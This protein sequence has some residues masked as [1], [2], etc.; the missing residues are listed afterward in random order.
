MGSSGF[1]SG[2]PPQL[3]RKEERARSFQ[4]LI[5]EPSPSRFALRLYQAETPVQPRPL[6]AGGRAQQEPHPPSLPPIIT[7]SPFPCCAL[8]SAGAPR[9]LPGVPWARWPWLLA[10]PWGSQPGSVPVPCSVLSPE[11]WWCPRCGAQ[12]EAF[13]RGRGSPRCFWPWAVPPRSGAPRRGRRGAG[14]QP[15]AGGSSRSRCLTLGTLGH[16]W[17]CCE[18]LSLFYCPSPSR[19]L[20]CPPPF[21]LSE[22]FLLRAALASLRPLRD[23]SAC[24]VFNSR[25]YWSAFTQRGWQ[26]R[27]GSCYPGVPPAN[28]K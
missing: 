23:K 28:L 14:G 21:L 11:P 2:F 15:G 7:R 16:L 18:L 24:W 19:E 27:A 26:G 1:T 3:V 20:C 10:T 22:P 13:G 6:P 5:L 4:K 12:G 25:Y 9:T 17:S 8:C